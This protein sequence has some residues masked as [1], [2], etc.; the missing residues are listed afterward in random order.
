MIGGVH[1]PDVGGLAGVVAVVIAPVT[2]TKV[3]VKIL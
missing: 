1:A 2:V 3:L